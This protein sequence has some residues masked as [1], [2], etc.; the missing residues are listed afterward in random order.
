[1]QTGVLAVPVTKKKKSNK[2]QVTDSSDSAVKDFAGTA[3]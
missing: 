2:S 3:L 1:M